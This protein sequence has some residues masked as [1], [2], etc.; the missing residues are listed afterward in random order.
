MLK[1]GGLIIQT[2][3]SKKVS[4]KL[5]KLNQQLIEIEKKIFIQYNI[6]ENQCK[7]L[8]AKV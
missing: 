1:I 3:I 4:E 6:I 2:K 5:D 8:K 7:E